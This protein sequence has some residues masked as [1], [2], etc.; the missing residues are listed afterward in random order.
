MRPGYKTTELTLSG[1]LAGAIYQLAEGGGDAA[2]AAG[3]IALAIVA[4]GYAIARGRA[5]G[6]G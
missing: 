4:V 1:V 6:A 3:C 2:R 5:K